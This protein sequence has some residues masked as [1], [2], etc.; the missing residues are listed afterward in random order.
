MTDKIQEL[1]D[2]TLLYR[3]C[4][5]SAPGD[6]P[7]GC[8]MYL[9]VKDGKLI[10]VEGDPEHPISQGRLC[11]RCLSLP[12]FVYNKDRI[13]KPM[14]RAREDRGKDNWEPCSWEEALD[15][16]EENV[17]HIQKDYGNEYCMVFQGTGREST[18]Y[19]P[20]L[21]YAVL[22]TPNITTALSGESCY[23]PRCNVANFILGAGYPELDYAAFFPDRY[24]DPRYV[25]PQYIVLWGKDPLSSNPDGFYGHSLID[26]MKRGS[27]FI[28]IDP[29]VTWLGAH[30][31]F[32]L[33]LR[34]GT[35]VAVGLGLINVIISED[36]YDHNFV[37]K[38]CYGFEELKARAAEFPPEKVEEITW[39]PQETL[40]G[41]ARAMATA[42]P[43]A[44]MWGLAM[45]MSTNGVQVGH[46]FLDV[47]AI[48]GN[49]DV[50][51]GVTLAVPA[52]FMGKWRYECAT[53]VPDEAYDK[54]L[55]A[56][57]LKK[58]SARAKMAHTDSVLDAMETGDPYKPK[59]V[60]F[61]ATNPLACNAAQPHRWHDAFKDF[62]FIVAQ[63]CV[64]TPTAM[65][66]AD[67]F[68]PVASFAEHDG[69]VLPQF[70]R[71]TH[72]LGA[73]NKAI[74]LGCKSD[75]E[76]DIM[77]G[78]RLNPEAWPWNSV[79]EFFSE[80]IESLGITFK[81]LQEQVVV[82]NTFE[83]YKYEKGLLRSD[84]YPGFNTP[85]GKV[86]LRSSI[87]PDWDEDGLPYFVEPPIS[88]YSMPEI[89]DDYPLVLTTGGRSHPY[90][91]S[92][93]RQMPSLR[94]IVPDPIV[95][96][97]PKTAEKAGITSGDWVCV[98]NMFGQCIQRA[99][100]S[101]VV[102][103]RVVHCQHGWWFPEQ[104]GQEDNL[105]GTYKA[106]PN[107]LV[108][109]HVVGKMGWGAPYK[110]MVCRIYKVDGLD[111]YNPEWPAEPFKIDESYSHD[112]KTLLAQQ[113]AE[114]E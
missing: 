32:H 60:W 16:I 25:I 81:E 22:R 67:V 76:I 7:V 12:E 27:Q 19:A 33:Q 109:H 47:C 29:R 56:P 51:G 87:Y 15:I 64:M 75:L 62:E 88:P 30:A 74:D 18:L 61:V 11:V 28:T 8:G 102:N 54:Q 89:V 21:A 52:S 50:P 113:A 40:I 59:M 78:K 114:K 92:E 90:F 53:W 66:L 83:Y 69:I 105:Y 3:T 97:H 98:E 44:F 106:N 2:G 41:A 80:Q 100:V 72:F 110:S 93:G 112:K 104:E 42:K 70:G 111:S 86:E 5:W 20:A 48:T 57:N 24:D 68:L 91:H 43:T 79:E 103:E 77:A 31:A 1:E 73:M 38:W 23:G 71:N 37:E 99:L 101:P 58:I 108:P 96:I 49:L 95:T 13:I 46:V 36:I 85:T 34:P 14:K 107:N 10:G 94:A 82:Q 6:H 4:G 63:D 55:I 39:I 84:G 35:D 17:R 65:A 26:L 45:D 9:K